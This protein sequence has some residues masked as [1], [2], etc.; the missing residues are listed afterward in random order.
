MPRKNHFN[1]KKRSWA[2]LMLNGEEIET[3]FIRFRR[4]YSSWNQFKIEQDKTEFRKK[5]LEEEIKTKLS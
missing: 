4:K 1:R 3:S 2:I 5:Q